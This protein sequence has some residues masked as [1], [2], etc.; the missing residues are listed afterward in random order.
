V[1][2]RFGLVLNLATA[3][4]KIILS[5]LV[6]RPF[7]SIKDFITMTIAEPITHAAAT[8][9]QIEKTVEENTELEKNKGISQ[10]TINV[11]TSA[12]I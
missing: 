7:P 2:P 5:T 9:I 12:K 8:H 11:D 10:K 6:I 1:E 4:R 3:V